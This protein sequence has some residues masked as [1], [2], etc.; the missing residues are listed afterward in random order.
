MAWHDDPTHQFAGIAEKLKRADQNII[1]L[2]SEFE[3][4][5]QSCEYPVIPK[6]NTQG[7]QEAFAY[8]RDKPIPLRFAVLAGETLHHLRSCLDHIVWHFSDA[9]SRSTDPNGIEFP[10]FDVEPRNHE[11]RKRYTR[12]VQG[13]TN[14]TVLGL[15]LD[16][17]PYMAG[18]DT[19]N[20]AL[21]IIHNMDRFD[22][23]RE[24]AIV[25]SGLQVEL[26]PTMLE[27]RHKAS[28]YTQGKLPDSEQIVLGKALQDYEASPGIAFREFG[29][30][31]P[32]SVIKGLAE[33][34]IATHNAIGEFASET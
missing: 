17:Q 28:L 29:Q 12:K 8:H 21:L 18:A 26:P 24:L 30:H 10:I 1:N 9:T 23:H 3:F 4:F 19:A 16:M 13:I 7:W 20:H 32:Y 31:R 22:K 15:I 14:A 6:P 27:L 2:Q 11:E 33:L 25:D 34:W 5:I